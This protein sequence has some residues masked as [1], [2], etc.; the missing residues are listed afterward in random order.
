MGGMQQVYPEQRVVSLE[1]LAP[2]Y[3]NQQTP[4]NN[5]VPFIRAMMIASIDGAVRGASGTSMDLTNEEDLALLSMLRACS[6]AVLVGA[7]TARAYPYRPPQPHQRW[8]SMRREAG[9][10]DAPRLVIVSRTGLAADDAC[11]SDSKNPPLF[12]VPQACPMRSELSTRA[13]VIIAGENDVDVT[14]MTKELRSRGI[15]R[16]VCEGGPTLL[17]LLSAAGLLDE[18]CL[19]TAPM[20]VGGSDVT[21]GYGA[22]SALTHKFELSRLFLGRDSYL[23]AQWRAQRGN[24]FSRS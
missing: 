12:V 1:D 20:W 24:S 11:F 13:E 4:E 2:D 10:S 8:V 17:S 18:L 3:L 9:L 15:L 14:T 19:T 23:F 6:D 21:L 16:I 22:A 7:A 5:D